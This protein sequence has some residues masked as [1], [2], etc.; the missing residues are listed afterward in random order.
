[1]WPCQL[2]PKHVLVT[3]KLWLQMRNGFPLQN[4]ITIDLSIGLIDVN[5]QDCFAF[6]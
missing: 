1:M 6:V 3:A 2:D 5:Q 4:C